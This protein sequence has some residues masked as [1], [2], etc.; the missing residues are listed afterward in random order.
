MA[1]QVKMQRDVADV[2]LLGW[3]QEQ[4]QSLSDLE[5]LG[6]KFSTI[7]DGD[8]LVAFAF[9]NS[10]YQGIALPDLPK[11]PWTC[12]VIGEGTLEEVLN[13]AV[14]R[15]DALEENS[16]AS[17]FHTR[18]IVT[19]GTNQL[20]RLAFYSPP[21]GGAVESRSADREIEA[22]VEELVSDQKQVRDMFC[23]IS[24]QVD[25]LTTEIQKLKSGLEST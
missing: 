13:S 10:D 11:G 3:V 7:A 18:L 14:K 19:P 5:N 21:I 15:L 4:M 8:H 6:G 17:A 16:R 1:W 2:S 9:W 23:N 20:G 24:Q 22:A 12:Q 25:A